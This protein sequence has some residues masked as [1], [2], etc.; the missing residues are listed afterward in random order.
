M[1]MFCLSI[2]DS[3]VFVRADYYEQRF[4]DMFFYY[5]PY[6]DRLFSALICVFPANL[7][8]SIYVDE[9]STDTTFIT[10]FERKDYEE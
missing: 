10:D 8:E 5:R 3:T 7:V 4:N 9:V 2:G 1:K 6:C